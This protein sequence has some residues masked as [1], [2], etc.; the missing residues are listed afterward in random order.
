M[1]CVHRWRGNLHENGKPAANITH[2]PVG[3]V[4]L[5]LSK[6][7]NEAIVWLI[8]RNEEWSIPRDNLTDLDVNKTGTNTTARY[9]IYVTV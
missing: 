7:D 1:G 5:L 8:G 3:S 4:G 9:A 6:K 2:F